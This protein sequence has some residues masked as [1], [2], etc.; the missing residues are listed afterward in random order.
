MKKNDGF[1]LIE[2]MVVIVIIGVLSAVAMPKFSKA[3]SKAIHSD[4]LTLTDEIRRDIHEF[5]KYRGRLPISNEEIGYPVKDS[6]YSKYVQSVNL[7]KGIVTITFKPDNYHVVR[8]TVWLK[9]IIAM[10]NSYGLL[11]WEIEHYYSE[12]KPLAEEE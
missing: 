4:A 12:G 5:Y 2:L 9:P 6:I 3:I 10:P 1:T 7:N 8:D 11:S